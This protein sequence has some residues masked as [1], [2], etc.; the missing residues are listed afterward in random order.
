MF[1]KSESQKV[2]NFLVVL[3][4]T[5]DSIFKNIL[6]SSLVLS[7]TVVFLLQKSLSWSKVTLTLVTFPPKLL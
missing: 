5:L 6:S 4:V 2:T 3:M 1:K 7:G